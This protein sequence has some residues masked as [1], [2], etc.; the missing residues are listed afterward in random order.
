MPGKTVATDSVTVTLTELEDN[1]TGV[2]GSILIKC[3]A[4]DIW[5]VLTDY[6]NFSRFVPRILHSKL[7]RDG[8][9]SKMIEQ[10]GQTGISFIRVR[11][12]VT[13][14]VEEE[15]LERISFSAVGGDFKVYAGS[16]FIQ[17]KPGVEGTMLHYQAR[18]KPRF[19]TPPALVRHVQ[20]ND[21]PQVLSAI[22][23]RVR[24]IKQ[25]K[26]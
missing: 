18:I 25:E 13:L 15:Y 10:I 11:A 8:G 14:E 3:P 21:L 4:E 12:R 23:Q 16:W 17:D 20:K 2:A 24:K 1:V 7:V 22:R 26:S 5:R 6:N 19:P 9:A